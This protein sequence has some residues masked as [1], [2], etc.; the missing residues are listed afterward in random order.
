MSKWSL[1]RLKQNGDGM[2]FSKHTLCVAGEGRGKCKSARNIT[3]LKLE[4]MEQAHVVRRGG[5]GR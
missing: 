2:V 3:K 1:N 5:G 4:R